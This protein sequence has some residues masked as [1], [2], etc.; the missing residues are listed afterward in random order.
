MQIPVMIEPDYAYSGWAQMTLNGIRTEAARLK[1]KPVLMESRNY[2]SLDWNAVFGKEQRLVIVLAPSISWAPEV[3]S[4]FDDHDIAAI[5]VAFEPS[6]AVSVRGQVRMDYVQA[7]QQLL[8]YLNEC[9]RKRI[10]LF[11]VNSNFFV[12]TLKTNAFKAWDQREEE[13]DSS[14]VFPAHRSL[15]ECYDAF[16]PHVHAYDAVICA[17]DTVAVFLLQHLKEDGLKV[18]EELYLTSFGNTRL[19]ECISPSITCVTEDYEETGRQAVRLF[20]W[21]T[22]QKPCANVSIRVRSRLIIRQSTAMQQPSADLRP[23]PPPRASL[24]DDIYLYCDREALAFQDI[25]KILVTC[26]QTDTQLIHGLLD[27]RTNAQLEEELFLSSYA[28]R[29]RLKR[30]MALTHC[31]RKHELI[32][33]LRFYQKTVWGDQP[34]E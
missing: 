32:D 10:A 19:S 21:L 18:P 3:L 12:D 27:S 8:L 4:F 29:Y 7:M 13:K 31:Q 14:P 22:R 20:S 2:A 34:A 16:Y 24:P 1:Y 11:G 30:L 9:G 33:F 17:N 23:S 6:E 15:A 28:L 5:W 26:D 25:E